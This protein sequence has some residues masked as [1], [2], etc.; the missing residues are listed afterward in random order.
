MH[1]YRSK[2]DTQ[3]LPRGFVTP[4]KAKAQAEVLCNTVRKRFRHLSRK[5]RRQDIDC[6]RLY[7]WDSPDI[8]VVVDW[9][10]GHLVVAE[11]ERIQTGPEYLPQMANAVAAVLNVPA[12]KLHIRRRHTKIASGPRYTK[13][14]SRGE[15]FQVRE[16]NLRFWVNVSDFL[17][18]GL[19]SD[20]RDTRV[21]LAKLAPGKSFLNLFSYTGTFTCAVAAGGAKTTVSVDR[22]ETYLYWAKDNL[23]SNGLW[24][25]QHTLAQSDVTKY[26]AHALHKGLRF[27]LAFVDPPSFSKDE[28]AGTAF[29]VIKDHPQLLKEVLKVMQPGSDLFFSTNHQRFV[30]NFEGLA[31]KDITALTPKTIPEDYRNRM[32]HSCWHI[33]V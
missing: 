18:T 10:A 19:F 3:H 26:L 9:Y 28:L 21:I 2:R 6:F 22:S 4:E 27:D 16:R 13:I 29:D 24:G 20:H 12:Q 14:D 17:D 23:V 30:S 33:K 7:D 8:R 11:Y 32:V 1:E 5:F 25:S 15:R 31:V